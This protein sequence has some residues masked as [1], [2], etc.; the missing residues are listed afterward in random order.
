MYKCTDYYAPEHER[1]I[2]WDDADLGIDWQLPDDAKPIL[3]DKDSAAPL[4][5]DADTYL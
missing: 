5:K 3:S 4:L 1:S 2:R